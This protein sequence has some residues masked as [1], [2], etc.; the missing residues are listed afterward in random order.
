MTFR[1]S[2]IYK[3][4][5]R[6][7]NDTIDAIRQEVS[8]GVA[9]YAWDSR[10]DEA[11]LLETDLIGL[12]GWTFQENRG[13][14][15]IHAGITIST[16]NDENLFREQAIVDAIHDAFGEESLIPMRD[17]TG[18]EYTQLVVKEFSMLSAGM[19][20]KRNYRPIG[21]ELKRT[22]NE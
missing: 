4:I 6:H 8:P 15:L 19:S 14:W 2:N 11:Q 9:Y 20:E 21:L 13:L 7:L 12:A 17:D 22:S 10:N 3:S 16:V 5:L 18:A 1:V